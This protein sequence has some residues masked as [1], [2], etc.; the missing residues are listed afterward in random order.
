MNVKSTTTLSTNVSFISGNNW[1]HFNIMLS[2]GA[3]IA[4]NVRGVFLS[5]P[6]HVYVRNDYSPDALSSLL[7]LQR[8][9]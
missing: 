7:A 6:E 9:K 5:Q 3:I 2:K 4:A 8:T 1:R